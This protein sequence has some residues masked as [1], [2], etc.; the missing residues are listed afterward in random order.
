MSCT[1]CPLDVCLANLDGTGPGVSSKFL[2]SCWH[3]K[4]SHLVDIFPFGLPQISPFLLACEFGELVDV[5][6]VSVYM[7]ACVQLPECVVYV[8]PFQSPPMHFVPSNLFPW[9]FV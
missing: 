7:H 2:S 1:M 9:N 8:F 3:P 5:V 4:G 6:H